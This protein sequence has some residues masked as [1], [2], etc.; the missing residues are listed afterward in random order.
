MGDAIAPSLMTFGQKGGRDLLESSEASGGSDP[1]IT[2]LQNVLSLKPGFLPNL[3]IELIQA[4][5]L[6]SLLAPS[7]KISLSWLVP[8]IPAKPVVTSPSD[9][10]WVEP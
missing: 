4:D 6:S 3:K 1:G 8:V 2:S 5:W 7:V 9:G 10:L